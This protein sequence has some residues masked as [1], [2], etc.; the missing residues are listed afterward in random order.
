MQN[1]KES[2]KQE[3]P[4]KKGYHSPKL[5]ACGSVKEHTQT[6]EAGPYPD[7]T[8]TTPGTVPSP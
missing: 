7:A 3:R 2:Q 1:T 6:G 4:P 8:W 5:R